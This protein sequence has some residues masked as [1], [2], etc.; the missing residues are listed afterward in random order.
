MRTAKP[1]GRIYFSIIATALGL[2]LTAAVIAYIGVGSINKAEI[3]ARDNLKMI[4]EQT[5][6]FDEIQSG[7]RIGELFSINENLSFMS[8]TLAID[9]SL[10]NDRYL[11]R[12]V[13]RT[14]ITGIAV[15][16]GELRLEASG[17]TR[18][19]IEEN[20][21]DRFYEGCLEEIVNNPEQVFSERMI[22]D[23]QYYD[24]CAVSRKD[25]AGVIVAYYKH[26]MN[27][28]YD[29][30]ENLNQ[31]IS[32]VP[33]TLDGDIIIVHGGKI[34]S[35]EAAVV[36]GDAFIRAADER[37]CYDEIRYIRFSGNSYYGMRA[38]NG[39]YTIYM[40][41]PAMS[42]FR[43][44]F[45]SAIYFVLIYIAL[46][47]AIL[48]YRSHMIRKRQ[49]M[50]E[51]TNRRLTESLSVLTSLEAIY[52][53]VFYV[54][55]RHDTYKSFATAPWIKNVVSES[56]RF[57]DSMMRLIDNSVMD[58]YKDQMKDMLGYEHICEQLHKKKISDL[59]RSFYFD[60]Q[61]DRA[62]QIF[63]CRVTVTAVDFD[64][65]GN[66]EHIL[67]MLQ[68]VNYE[69]QREADYQEQIL[70]ESKLAQA[71]NR[72]KSAFLFNISHDI[73]T[74]MTAIIGY[75]DLA[76]K[77]LCDPEKAD[78]YLDNIQTSGEALLS[79]T[80]ELLEFARVENGTAVLC[81]YADKADK[82]TDQCLVMIRP[83]AQ[84]KNIDIITKKHIIYPYV[85]LD[86]QHL[87]RIVLNLLNNAVK[88]T[89]SNGSVTCTL[90]QIA[91]DDTKSCT[92][93]IT[94]SD[95][96]IGISRE[97]MPH[98]FEAFER[99][100]R[101]T[102]QGVEGTGLGLGIVKNL[103]ELM[104]G[105]INVESTL[106]MGTSFCVSIPCLVADADDVDGDMERYHIKHGFGV[107]RVLVA[108]DGD[109]NAEI[110][111]VMLQEEGILTE[112]ARDG[113]ECISMLESKPKGYY[114]L[115]LMDIQMPRS[116]GYTAA[117]R[118]R[119]M[120]IN[121]PIVAMSANTYPE[122]VE[123]SLQAGMNGHLSKPINANELMLTLVK[124]I[125]VELTLVQ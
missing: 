103:V 63:W 102:A 114:G 32:T 80:N 82:V 123:R 97:F 116:D 87:M 3:T 48:A 78:R 92:V 113:E 20:W 15:L 49:H 109:L 69:K 33:M 84:K 75:S 11:E 14:K 38:V 39:D 112:R 46:Y 85:H 2:C 21:K 120:G 16:D 31:L 6:S 26:S 25:T 108:E 96:G 59:R 110:V 30:E 5:Y 60:Y 107:K 70:Y 22:V 7:D 36:D 66:P 86:H 37:F 125:D 100:K 27:L 73:R 118:I 56:G 9:P 76:K 28:V 91:H 18:D 95:T 98:I 53:T 61:V 44:A 19:L 111:S 122:D 94:I 79:I 34:I 90:D 13:D 89:E 52:F 58:K 12:F 93:K 55:L 115:V 51:E 117:H 67:I 101:I 106:G 64:R 45:V 23:G 68:D 83:R 8:D 47:F 99:D 40:Y 29:T 105:T 77:S 81:E 35:G 4:I 121:I 1:R 74:P 88:F 62:G 65:E 10:V 24:V 42:L 41:F 43:S 104:H 72:A 54:D 119:E 124:Y 17:Y 57:L 71:A 50:L